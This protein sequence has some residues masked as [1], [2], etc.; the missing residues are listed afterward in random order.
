MMATTAAPVLMSDF[1]NAVEKLDDTGK[2]CTFQCRFIIAVRQKRVF[3]H[4]DGTVT[5]PTFSDPLTA[6][7]VTAMAREGRHGDISPF[8][9]AS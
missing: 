1:I 9:E 3:D 4:F 7:E 2:N 5:K 8:A 6:A